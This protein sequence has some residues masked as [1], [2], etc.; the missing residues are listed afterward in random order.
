MTVDLSYSVEDNADILEWTCMTN[1]SGYLSWTDIIRNLNTFSKD[2]A[3]ATYGKFNVTHLSS[4]NS[5]MASEFF[6]N[7]L[8]DWIDNLCYRVRACGSSNEYPFKVTEHGLTFHKCSSP[9]YQFQLL[10]SLNNL[11]KENACADKS[12]PAHKLFEELSAAAAG[13]YLGD[14]DTSVV[15]GFPR[16]DLPKGFR[17][18]VN[19]LA[20]LLR[21]G[22][23]CRDRK[24]I[25]QAKDDKLDIV[26][27]REFPDQ[28]AS[29][30][31]LFGQC[32]ISR[33]WKKKAYELQP[34]KWCKRN[35]ITQPAVRPVP[36]FFVPQILS[37][38]SVDDA[39]INQILLDR[40]RISAL[41]YG[42]LNAQLESRLWN[43]IRYTLS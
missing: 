2:E 34:E 23:A 22:T 35:F 32:A 19:H 6:E 24:G 29:K 27:W 28:K 7:I 42:T 5:D 15:F 18:A 3:T 25:H 16:N 41:C 4:N 33:H 14:S 12:A 13:Q 1:S 8:Q 20:E 26:A 10:V 38:N 21:E 36:V 43:W 40:C 9:A 39:G 11:K 17:D 37:E 31:I 30:L